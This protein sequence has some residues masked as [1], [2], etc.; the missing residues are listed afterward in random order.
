MIARGCAAF[1]FM[2]CL[3]AMTSACSARTPPV[4]PAPQSDQPDAPSTATVTPEPPP[5][6]AIPGREFGPG[7]CAV[8]AAPG[9][10]I[11]TV[12]LSDRIDPSNAPRPSNDSERLLFRQ[13]YETLVR[14]D[15]MSR[16]GP[17]LATSWRRLDDDGRSWIVILRED[18]RFSDG[19]PVERAHRLL[20][21]ESPDL[22][23]AFPD[24]YDATPGR[25]S[26]RGWCQTEGHLRYPQVFPWKPEF[27]PAHLP[28]LHARLS[29]G[30]MM[31]L[32][33]LMMS[34]R[35]GKSL[36]GRL[37]RMFQREGLQGIARRLPG[38]RP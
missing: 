13:L 33:L 23:K 24:P 10:S 4:V 2:V 18:A 32:S 30:A 35:G 21:R 19:T 15:C 12:G 9:D 38:K 37:Y 28:P 17:S 1:G 36:R 26:F 11:A 34:P 6:A 31:R 20:Y 8:V 22:H 29:V 16:V 5:A 25:P 14:V 3:Q 7:E 27:D